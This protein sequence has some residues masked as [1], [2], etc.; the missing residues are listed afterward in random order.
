MLWGFSAIV[1]IYEAAEDALH[2]WEI[3]FA[4]WE[5]MTVFQ[6]NYANIAIHGGGSGSWLLHNASQMTSLFFWNSFS[7]HKHHENLN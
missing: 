5:C 2:K 6:V 3:W 1:I 4:A 7:I